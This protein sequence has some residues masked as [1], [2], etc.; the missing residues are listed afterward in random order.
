[1]YEPESVGALIAP[2]SSVGPLKPPTAGG[3]EFLLYA[4][5]EISK[6]RIIL[7]NADLP[8]DPAMTTWKLSRYCPVL[9][10]SSEDNG[11]PQRVHL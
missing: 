9:V 2:P 4:K 10:A 8:L 5:R 7:N 6:L 3:G 11:A 1:M